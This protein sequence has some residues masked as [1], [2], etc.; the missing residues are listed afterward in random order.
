MEETNLSLNVLVEIR[1]CKKIRSLYMF[2]YICIY[3]Y[4]YVYM[5]AYIYL[6]LYIFNI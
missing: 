1:N 2:I 5:Y 3:V 4:M 6:C